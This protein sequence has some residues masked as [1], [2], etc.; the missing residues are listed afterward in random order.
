MNLGP[1][2]PEPRTDVDRLVRVMVDHVRSSDRPSYKRLA[3]A[4]L[5]AGYRKGTS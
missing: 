2:E 1:P 3:Q 5:D 4:V